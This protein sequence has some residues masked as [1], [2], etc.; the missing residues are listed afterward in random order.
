M[1]LLFV[2]D[3]MVGGSGRSQRELAAALVH[4]GHEVLFLVDPSTPSGRT[5][6]VYEQLSD[7]AERF[8]GT[9]AGRFLVLLE[10]FPGRRASR[11]DV[12]GL[13][14]VTTPVIE[15]AAW[16]VTRSFRPDV[17]VGSSVS[18]LGW[19][20]IRTLCAR[21][22]IP[23]L[24]YVRE[25][26][27]LGHFTDGVVPGDGFV[28]NA[29]GLAD[30]VRSLGLGCDF[31]PS[32]VDVGVTRGDSTREK[33]LA[34]NPIEGRGVRTV[35]DLA[36]KLPKIPFVVQES[37]ALDPLQLAH[38]EEHLA[39]LPNVEFRR[40]EPAGPRL[41]RDARLLLVPH[42]GGDRPRIIV[43]AQANG[44]PV[45]CGNHPTLVDAVGPGGICLPF[46]DLGA[47][48]EAVET[49]WTDV[50]AYASLSEAAKTHSSRP[51]ISAEHVAAGFEHI[52]SRLVAAELDARGPERG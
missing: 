27:A 42:R 23:T 26:S 1:R 9:F 13:A 31:L 48:R 20:K 37:W 25:D 51:D 38:V 50:S 7:A 33:V 32:V 12:D 34:V 43:E 46:D 47:W 52:V 14:H 30:A 45:L 19:R 18:R 49:L 8:S 35:W 6:W 15:N 4:R 41:Y 21:L 40:A 5:P 39:R 29:P 16:S 22:G 44:I 11:R 2:S 28:A 3:S 17:I 36:E 24:L 10:A